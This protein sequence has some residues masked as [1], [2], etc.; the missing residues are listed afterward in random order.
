MKM[1]ANRLL[2]RWIPTMKVGSIY[3]PESERDYH[4]TD[5]VKMFKVIAAGPGHYTRKGVFV[6]NEINPGDNVIVDS[7]IS[8]RP[9]EAGENQFIIKN[10]AVG[11]IAVV[12]LQAP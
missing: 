11:V 7:R 6:P 9:E 2:V 4:N 5:S 8:G 12:P 1:T 3:M 10:P